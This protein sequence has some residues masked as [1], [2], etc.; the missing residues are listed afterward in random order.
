MVGGE[1]IDSMIEVLQDEY[2][3]DRLYFLPLYSALPIHIQ[4]SVFYPTPPNKRK[5]I[6]STN[7]AEASITVDGIRYVIDSGYVKLNYFDVKT[8]LDS[9]ITCPISK[10]TAMQ[11]AGR[12]G[13]TEE[14]KCYRLLTE[15]DYNNKLIEYP[16]TEMERTDISGAIL[17]LKALGIDDIVHFDFLSSPPIDSIIFSLELLY[18]LGSIDI[19]CKLT[20]IGSEMAEMPIE[21]RL[22]NTLLRSFDFGCGEEMLTISAMCSVEYPFIT[23]RKKGN[24]L[25]DAKTKL[26][27]DKKEFYIHD[28]DH[29]T[30][31][32]I[33]NQFKESGYSQSWC[34]SYSLQYRILL[35]A[36]EIRKNLL[37]ILKKSR[38]DGVIISSCGD[39]D[40]AIK[41]CLVS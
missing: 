31:L 17:Q 22:A 40:I 38:S 28:S 6:L 26:L 15:D 23:I 34:D 14:G 36:K 24:H 35:R 21:P 33:Y 11:R 3:G 5:V 9:L 29:L 32:N 12:A 16:P 27:K 8:G 4:Q 1:E 20:K 2:R 41:K 18:S 30:L 13:R 39:D 10:A 37:S 19:D 7:I 25:L